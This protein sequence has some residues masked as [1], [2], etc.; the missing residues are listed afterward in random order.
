VRQIASGVARLLFAGMAL[1]LIATAV[2]GRALQSLLF[3]V[4][5]LDPAALLL[6]LVTVA[7]ASI[8][9]VFLPA[10]RAARVDPVIAIRTE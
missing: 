5:S 7:A 4:D 2:A 8:V 3:G 6:T 9:A 10:R 1:G